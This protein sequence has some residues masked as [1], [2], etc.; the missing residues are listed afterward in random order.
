M[1]GGLD[2]G[3]VAFGLTAGAALYSVVLLA[4]L[5]VPS[6]DGQALFSYGGP[7][8]LAIFAQPLV[9]TVVMFGLLRARCHT[10]SRAA[11]TAAR[12]IAVAYLLYSVLAGF[13]IAAG[14]L[15]A[16]LL[17]ALATGLTPAGRSDRAD[18]H[19]AG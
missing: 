14:A 6:V 12:S 1:F 16:A 17:L 9:L 11:T 18:G 15:P 3:R 13:S 19:T 5:T 2:R 7:W 4:S 10:G 8:T